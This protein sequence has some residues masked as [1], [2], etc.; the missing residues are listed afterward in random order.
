MLYFVALI[1]P[2]PLKEQIHQLK[3]KFKKHYHSRHALNAPPH[4]TLLSPFRLKNKQQES[5]DGLLKN[6]LQKKVRFEVT[7]NDF[8]HFDKWVLFIDVTQHKPLLYL[9]N[10]LESLARNHQDIFNYTYK[11][12]LF[13][14]HI[15]LAFKD[16]SKPDFI[17]AWKKFKT[18]KFQAEFCAD[19]I[20]LLKHDGTKWKTEQQYKLAKPHAD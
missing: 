6:H 20:Y 5:V 11:K 1:P 13:H 8:G 7:L 17:R 10:Q 2:D 18:K 12:R 3:L 4:I 15:T 9:Q 16:L 19:S 14:P